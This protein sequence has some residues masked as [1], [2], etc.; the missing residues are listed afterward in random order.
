MAD[1]SGEGWTWRFDAALWR[2]LRIR[3]MLPARATCAAPRP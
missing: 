2:N 3:D 1:G